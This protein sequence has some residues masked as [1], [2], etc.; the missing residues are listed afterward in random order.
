VPDYAKATEEQLWAHLTSLSN[1]TEWRAYQDLDVGNFD[2]QGDQAYYSLYE[3]N[4]RFAHPWPELEAEL[5]RRNLFIWLY[6]TSAMLE[7]W[8]E[9]AG[10]DKPAPS[11]RVSVFLGTERQALVKREM[12]AKAGIDQTI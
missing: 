10:V 7:D 1:E 12:Q 5:R 6:K 8:D 9:T 4:K 3:L 2:A 11:T